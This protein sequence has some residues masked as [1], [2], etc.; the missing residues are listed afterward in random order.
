MSQL[1]TFDFVLLLIISEATQ[2]AILGD[3]FAIVGGALAILTLIVLDR[4]S[5]LISSRSDR[6][7]RILTDGGSSSSRTASRMPIAWRRSV[8]TTT[9]S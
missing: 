7:D 6:L 9:T 5:D 8:S 4:V 3:D 1:T 2:Q